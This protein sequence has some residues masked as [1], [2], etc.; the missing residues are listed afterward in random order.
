MTITGGG[1]FALGNA[2]LRGYRFG[3]P[4]DEPDLKTRVGVEY[5]KMYNKEMCEYKTPLQ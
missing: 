2:S 5:K 1:I 4:T 3:K